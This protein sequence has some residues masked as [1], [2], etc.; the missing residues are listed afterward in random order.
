M[1]PGRKAFISIPKAIFTPVLFVT[2]L[3]ETSSIP[4]L[5]GSCP[6]SGRRDVQFIK[7]DLQQLD[8]FTIWMLASAVFLLRYLLLAGIPFMICYHWQRDRWSGK[9][10]QQSFPGK[11]QIRAEILQSARTMLLYGI[12]AGV[13]GYWIGNG[14]TRVYPE[15]HE[16]GYGY[17]AVS[18][19]LML[20]LH[21]AYFYWT[22]RL[23]HTPYLFRFV[24][25]VHHGHKSPTP[26]S[27]FS[28]HPIEALLSMGIIP[29]IIFL[30]PWHHYAL[31]VFATVMTL[32][33]VYI[34]LGIRI[35]NRRK[36]KW[37]NTTSD[38]DLHHQG[39]KANYGLY[40]TVWDHL[41]GTYSAPGSTG[42]G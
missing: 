40:S 25:R 3:T 41:M 1:Q 21:D 23:L 34:H 39:V 26:W 16:Y 24:H 17:F 12:G 9:K 2:N 38:H 4:N 36:L 5:S 14:Y 37:Q 20:L 42:R 28:F 35:G 7:M 13:L 15:L 6:L 11:K 31:I 22:H 32:Y 10:I 27:A 29:L 30:I 18:I 19:L 33:D 8:A